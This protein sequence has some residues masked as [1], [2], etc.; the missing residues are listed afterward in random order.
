MLQSAG[1]GDYQGVI[2]I[3]VLLSQMEKK[4]Y[5][6][7]KILD[8]RIG[9]WKQKSTPRTP[10]LKNVDVIIFELTEIINH[11]K[12]KIFQKYHMNHWNLFCY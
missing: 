10:T 1:Y 5:N 6:V 8:T 3:G 4:N 7:F 11:E 9:I 2:K 12:K